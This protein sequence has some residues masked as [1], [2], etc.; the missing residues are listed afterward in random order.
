V[1]THDELLMDLNIIKHKIVLKL[2]NVA[3]TVAE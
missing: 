1:G 3:K 2:N